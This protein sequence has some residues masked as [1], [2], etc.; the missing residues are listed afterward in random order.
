MSED[1]PMEKMR[2][3]PSCRMQISVLATKCRF[4]GEEVGK[5]KDESRTLSIHDLGG[6]H[7]YHRAPSGS[8]ME[9]LEA[10]RVDETL[11]QSAQP[12]S[13]DTLDLGLNPNQKIPGSGN[14]PSAFDVEYRPQPT[15]SAKGKKKPEPKSRGGLIAGIVVGVLVLI[16]AVTAGPRV[17]SSFNKPV[18]DPNAVI[19]VNRAPDILRAGGPALDALSAAV[20]AIAHEDSTKNKT[21]AED[22][23]ALLEKEVMEK[24]NATPFDSANLNAASSL[25]TRGADLYPNE[26]TR[27]LVSE[28]K[29][30]NRVYKMV[31]VGI[32]TATD[33][34][35]FTLNEDNSPHVKVREGE[36][37]SARFTVS[38]IVG[39]KS[40]TLVDTKRANRQV[41]YEIGSP[42]LPVK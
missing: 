36:Y 35:E 3:C 9:A 19:Y 20:D 27:R 1:A 18:V 16:G 25:A 6:E 15:T 39:R 29:E 10:F 22:A 26:V 4:C 7:V 33:A 40:V 32:D 11:Q 12:G 34:A 31:L 14:A 38:N 42:P 17:L 21:I 41:M 5:P 23:V 30:D 13:L 24:L 8:V 2:V 37:V 28:T